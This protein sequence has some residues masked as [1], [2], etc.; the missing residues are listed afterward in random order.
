MT[1]PS[2]EGVVFI[3][4]LMGFG[5]FGSA[6]APVIQYFDH[7]L[8]DFDVPDIRERCIFHEPPPTGSLSARVSSLARALDQALSSSPRRGRPPPTKWHLV[9]HSTGGLDARLLVNRLYS[10]IGGPT[11]SEKAPLLARI[12]NVVSISAP[13]RGAPIA[14]RV[15]RHADGAL[16]YPVT[17]LLRAAYGLSIAHELRHAGLRVRLASALLGQSWGRALAN[18]DWRVAEQLDRFFSSIREDHHLLRDLEPATMFDL[19]QRI[20]RGDCHTIHSFATVSPPPRLRLSGA[21]DALVSRAIYAAAHHYARPTARDEAP[22]P[23]VPYADWIG[24]LD[25]RFETPD[26]NDG[27]VPTASQMYDGPGRRFAVLGDHLDVV[28]HFKGVGET[29]FK[30]DANMDR[31]RFRRLWKRVLEVLRMTN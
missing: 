4:G 9:G 25:T 21:G 3:P 2:N 17:L 15:G 13:L 6:A 14:A 8:D 24:A 28:G 12:G 18:V 26:A 16:D 29:F 11:A 23:F 19:N 31:P 1:L 30:S 10:G 20:A 22:F 27:I 7:V 5:R